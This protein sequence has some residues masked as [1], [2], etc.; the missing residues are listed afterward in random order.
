MEITRQHD[1]TQIIELE[2]AKCTN[3][4]GVG[5][6]GNNGYCF[7]YIQLNNVWY[8]FFIQ[9]GIL[10]WIP[11]EPDPEEDLAD[12]EYYTDILKSNNINQ[13]KIGLI[14]MH[15]GIMI[16]PFC[17]GTILHLT[18]NQNTEYIMIVKSP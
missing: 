1:E 2:S 8:R 3:I 7:F 16:I 4:K 12:N 10:F 6:G 18:E 5:P 15:D 11:C 17:D 14:T 13:M 9:H